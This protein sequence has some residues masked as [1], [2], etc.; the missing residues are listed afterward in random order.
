MFRIAHAAWSVASLASLA[1]VWACA[2]G[3][4]RDRPLAGAVAFL[5][6]EGLALIVGRGDC[7][8]APL[9]RRLGDPVPLFELVLPA[10]AAKAA[11][12]VLTLVTIGGFAA[13]I[14]RR[15]LD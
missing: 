14:V 5:S 1:Y 8:M 3:R 4:R 10:A 7:P 6:L 9:Q 11:I 12:P 13:L 2:L 15:P